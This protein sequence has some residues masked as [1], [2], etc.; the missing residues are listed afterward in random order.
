M[1]ATDLPKII[2]VDDH[3]VEPAHLFERW[4]PQKFQYGAP[5][6]VERRMVSLDTD[7]FGFEEDENGM[8]SDVWVFGKSIYVPR[9]A[10]VVLDASTPPPRCGTRSR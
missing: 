9:R 5:P 2:S 7:L 3:L 10:V 4:L 8:P 6:R 1:T